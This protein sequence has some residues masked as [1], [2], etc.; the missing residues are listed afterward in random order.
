[1]RNYNRSGRRD[2]PTLPTEQGSEIFIFYTTWQKLKK[3]K[4]IIEV[5][6]ELQQVSKSNRNLATRVG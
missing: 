5:E 4:K 6:R 3:K 2:R 1:M